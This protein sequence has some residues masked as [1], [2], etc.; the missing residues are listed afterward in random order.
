MVRAEGILESACCPADDLLP[1]VEPY[2]PVP[3]IPVVEAPAELLP[4]ELPEPCWVP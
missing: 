1:D 3:L 2:C 4:E